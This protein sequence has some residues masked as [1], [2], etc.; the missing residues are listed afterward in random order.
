MAKSLSALVVEAK[1]KM[2]D[3]VEY[4][5]NFKVWTTK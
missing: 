5:Y 3:D 4:S 1:I 2:G